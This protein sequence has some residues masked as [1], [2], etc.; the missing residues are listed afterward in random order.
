MAAENV[1]VKGSPAAWPG[2]AAPDVDPTGSLRL[3]QLL[4]PAPGEWIAARL[5]DH[6]GA[7]WSTRD[8]PP[9]VSPADGVALVAGLLRAGLVRRHRVVAPSRRKHFTFTHAL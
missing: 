3:R 4:D 8:L 2:P 6:A 7:P 5:A 9:A 1:F